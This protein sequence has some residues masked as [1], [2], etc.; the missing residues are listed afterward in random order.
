MRLYRRCTLPI[1]F[2][3]L[4]SCGSWEFVDYEIPQGYVGWVS[5]HYGRETCPSYRASWLTGV[6]AIGADG[7]ACSTRAKPGEWVRS[8]F[9]YVDQAGARIRELRYGTKGASGSAIWSPNDSGDGLTN[10][11]YVGSESQFN[12]QEP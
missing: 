12:N 11:F 9:F 7:S 1:L 4:T 2:L 5:V 6:I 10:G 3:V 8:H